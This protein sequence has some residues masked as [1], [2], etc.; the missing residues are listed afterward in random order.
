MKALQKISFFFAVMV[1]TITSTLELR[2]QSDKLL[3]VG[4]IQLALKKLNVVGSAMYLA[5]HP[6]DEN[7]VVI[8]YLSQVKLMNT[9]YLA[10]NRGS[11][12]QNLI[13]PE[14]RELLGVLRTQELLMARG[15]DGSKQFFTR[16]TD[17]GYSKSAKETLELWDKDKVLSDVVW[18]IRRFRPDVIITRFPADGRGGH[19]HHTSSAILAIEAFSLAG[20]SSAY[21]EQLTYFPPWQ[22]KRIVLNETSWF[23]EKIEEESAVND[24]IIAVDCG[25]YIPYLGKSVTEIAAE[26]RSKHVC[27]GFGSTGTRG[28][29]LEYFRHINGDMAK[30]DLFDGINTSWSRVKGGEKVSLLLKESDEL[31]DPENPSAIVPR[32]LK[33]EAA[34]DKLEDEYWKKVKK[35]EIHLIIQS[36][37]GL[38]LEARTGTNALGRRLRSNSIPKPAEYWA[39]PG[40]AVTLNVEAI[41]RSAVPVTLKSVTFTGVEKDTVLNFQL[42]N[43]EDLNFSTEATIPEDASYSGPYWLKTHSDSEFMYEVTDQFLIGLP[44]APPPLMASFTLV[45]NGDEVVIK[46]PVVY[47]RNDPAKGETIRPFE[48]TPPVFLNIQEPVYVFADE[49]PKEIKILVKSGKENISGNVSLTVPDGWI[50]EPASIPF[51]FKEKSEEM[52]VTFKINS[53]EDKSEGNVSAVATIDGKTYN[54][55]LTIIDYEH[56]PTQTIFMEAQ[57]KI[58]KLDLK[59]KGNLIGYLMGAGDDIPKGLQQIG[60]QVIMLENKDMNLAFLEN[61]DAVILGIRAFNTVDRL[62]YYRNDLMKYVENGGTLIVQYNTA[63]ALVTD[64][65]GPYPITLSRDRVTDETA[66]IHFLQPNHSL[67]NNPNKITESDFSGWVQERGLYFPNEWDKHYEA[68]LSL[69]DPD[70]KVNNG[71]LLVTKYGKGYYI[72]TGLSFFR[73]IPAGVPGAY[74]LLT[75]LISIGKKDVPKGN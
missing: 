70:E 14:I 65:I 18:N 11:G 40:E 15:V 8:G 17:F 53:T 56:I 74:R 46:K 4:E 43:N 67:L 16:A 10:L 22:P 31:F 71:S 5:A 27:Q 49:R 21:P 45:I 39:T 19:G 32:L 35:D 2:A 66:E 12:G 63:H 42:K 54:K 51:S 29:N 23:S 50:V 13:G 58:V 57:A 61:L 30:E 75:N 9:A 37:L 47:K 64:K 3:S 7:Q 69:N 48:I 25:T 28:T 55:S 44:E 73:E 62:R 24:S 60:Y 6:D 41:N 26:S 33:A 59:K 20:D 52:P 38:Y 68:I 1:L 34:L 36:C 72:Y